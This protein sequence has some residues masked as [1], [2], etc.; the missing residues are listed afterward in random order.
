MRSS[1]VAGQRF[2]LIM[3]FAAGGVVLGA[4]TAMLSP[5][6]VAAVLTMLGTR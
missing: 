1:S 6:V 4:V 5:G 2:A 3:I